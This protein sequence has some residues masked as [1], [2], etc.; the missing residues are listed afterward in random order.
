MEIEK[1]NLKKIFTK[2]KKGISPVLSV[3][4][5]IAIAVAAALVAY[6]WVL[7]YVDTTTARAGQAIQIQSTA[8]D[9]GGAWGGG[10]DKITVYVQNVGQSAVDI[11]NVFIDGSLESGATGTGTG[12]LPQGATATIVVDSKNF[13][14][15]QN[16]KLKIVC[17]DGVSAESLIIVD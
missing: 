12:T 16:I 8:F 13:S 15:G 1:R 2:D 11:T 9:N 14:A 5:M 7:G 3:L 4:L 10:D 17:I 6:T